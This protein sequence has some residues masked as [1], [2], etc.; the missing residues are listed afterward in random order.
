MNDVEKRAHDIALFAAS[1]K[2]IALLNESNK[3]GSGLSYS[4]YD[5]Y[6]AAY[7]E[8]LTQVKRDFEG[9]NN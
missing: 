8:A 5:M 1:S 7:F 2:I 9:S 4:Y 6:K 3:C